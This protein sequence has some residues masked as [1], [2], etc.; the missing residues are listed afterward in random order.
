MVEEIKRDIDLDSNIKNV[1][2]EGI[3][4]NSDESMTREREHMV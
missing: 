4:K 3:D 2:G 1:S